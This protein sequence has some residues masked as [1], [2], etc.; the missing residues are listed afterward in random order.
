MALFAATLS[1]PHIGGNINQLA[2]LANLGGWP[3]MDEINEARQALLSIRKI[4]IRAFGDQD[5]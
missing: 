5:V 3:G 1:L 4:M 2:K